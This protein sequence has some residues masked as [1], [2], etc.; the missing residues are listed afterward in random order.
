MSIYLRDENLNDNND[1]SIV[2]NVT[3]RWK[4]ALQETQLVGLRARSR[5]AQH[6]KRVLIIVESDRNICGLC[7]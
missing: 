3:T 7:V 5:R 6:F 1:T 2:A 4:T